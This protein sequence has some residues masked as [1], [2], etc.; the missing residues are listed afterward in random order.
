MSSTAA[1]VT[2]ACVGFVIVGLIVTLPGYVAID[3]RERC[4]RLAL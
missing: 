3:P 4:W 2:F 1:R